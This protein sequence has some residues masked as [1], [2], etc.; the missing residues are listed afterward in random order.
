MLKRSYKRMRTNQ[1]R[2]KEIS[3][4]A[5]MPFNFKLPA[6][7]ILKI[8]WRSLNFRQLFVATIST[9]VA[10]TCTG[11]KLIAESHLKM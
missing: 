7:M 9:R 10:L 8:T 3:V 11:E 1:K 6:G 4:P 5:Q 2:Y